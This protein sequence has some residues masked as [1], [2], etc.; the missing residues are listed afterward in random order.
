MDLQ[1]GNRIAIANDYWK[2]TIIESPHSNSLHAEVV[3]WRDCLRDGAC[4]SV[5]SV[6][7]G[8]NTISCRQLARFVLGQGDGNAH[9]SS[10]RQAD[11]PQAF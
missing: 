5:V 11:F 8:S 3:A 7:L 1:V 9:Y 2:L 4:L 6:D 10:F